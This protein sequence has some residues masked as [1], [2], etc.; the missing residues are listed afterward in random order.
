VGRQDDDHAQELHDQQRT[1]SA[2][3]P[4]QLVCKDQS[5][6]DGVEYVAFVGSGYGATGEGTTLFTL[7]V[8]TGDVVASATVP[9]ASGTPTAGY[10]NALVASRRRSRHS[11]SPSPER[12]TSRERRRR[13]SMLATSTE[14]LEVP[15]SEARRAD[16]PEGLRSQPAN[17]DTRDAEPP[18]HRLRWR[19]RRHRQRP[20]GGVERERQV[21]GRRHGGHRRNDLDTTPPSPTDPALT[22]FVRDFEEEFRGTVQPASAFATNGPVVFFGGTRFVPPPPLSP[23]PPAIGR[24]SDLPLPLRQHHLRAE[25]RDGRRGLST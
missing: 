3:D 17:R 6:R 11:N 25:G 14:G 9:A 7:D 8:L 23:C 1:V 4:G 20:E 21:Q 13:A 10:A 22:L 5:R 16:S 19:L 2:T 24:G 15:G 18:G 12:P